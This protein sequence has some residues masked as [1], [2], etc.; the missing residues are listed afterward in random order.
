MHKSPP[1][2]GRDNGHTNV[3]QVFEN[4]YALIMRLTPHSRICDIPE[5]RK[6]NARD[7]VTSCPRENHDLIGSVLCNAVKG[8]HELGVIISSEVQGAAV[9]VKLDGQNTFGI[10]RHVYAA[11]S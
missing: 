7:K 8:V 6:V 4:L 2:D 1:F 5:C 10:T 3:G 11:V 9:C